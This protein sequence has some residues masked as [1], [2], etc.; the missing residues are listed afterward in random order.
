MVVTLSLT[1]GNLVPKKK[2]KKQKEKNIAKK[3]ET[4]QEY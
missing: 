3:K 2:K 1:M 4:K